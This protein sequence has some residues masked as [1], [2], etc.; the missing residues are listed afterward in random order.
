MIGDNGGWVFYPPAAY[1][2]DP[3]AW[4]EIPRSLP[5]QSW[6]LLANLTLPPAFAGW[7]SWRATVGPVARLIRGRG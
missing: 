2:T 1:S 4:D 3:S 6:R 7:S 5:G